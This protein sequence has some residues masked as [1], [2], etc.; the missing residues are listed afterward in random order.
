MDKDNFNELN[1]DV[2]GDIWSDLQKAGYAEKREPQRII[3]QVPKQVQA[4]FLQ[5][6]R[7]FIGR[8]FNCF[9][10]QI[11][12]L[13]DDVFRKLRS[14]ALC[15]SAEHRSV[16]ADFK[17]K[18]GL[19]NYSKNLDVHF[20]VFCDLP[21]MPDPES[22]TALIDGINYQVQPITVTNNGGNEYES[23]FKNQYWKYLEVLPFESVDDLLR[24]TDHPDFSG[25]L[26][27]LSSK[28]LIFH[29]VK[30]H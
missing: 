9:R 15:L 20:K 10:G 1:K 7:G 19:I 28:V 11:S 13:P 30:E 17:W 4:L 16:E 5:E 6:W 21:T 22:R 8:Q 24:L 18:V 29:P 2:K 27:L 12:L 25:A 3:P 26:K 23:R 14:Q